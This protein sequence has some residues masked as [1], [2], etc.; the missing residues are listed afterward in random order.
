M[1]QTEKRRKILLE[2]TRNL[3][4]TNTT[5]YPIHPRYGSTIFNNKEKEYDRPKTF[6][7]RLFICILLFALYLSMDYSQ[8]MLFNINSNQIKKIV[9]S[10]YKEYGL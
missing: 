10:D 4:S 8:N 7:T 5:D 2:E 9:S 1:N 6:M 3:Y